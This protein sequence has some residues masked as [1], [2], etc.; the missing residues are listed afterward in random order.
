[1]NT[2]TCHH[3]S[4]T[5]SSFFL[6]SGG[7]WCGGRPLRC[8]QH[9]SSTCLKVFKPQAASSTSLQLV[10]L[11]QSLVIIFCLYV[12]FL[13][14]PLITVL[15][16]AVCLARIPVCLHIVKKVWVNVNETFKCST[17]LPQL[18]D[19]KVVIFVDRSGLTI[20]TSAVVQDM[21][22]F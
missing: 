7:L 18:C 21:S 1:M 2:D 19:I 13:C 5:K 6:G 12:A 17:A 8:G 11:Y 3:Y 16:P 9:K 10:S 4:I 20:C 14:L 22:V 15:Q